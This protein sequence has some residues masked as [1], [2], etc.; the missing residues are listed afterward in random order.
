VDYY[1]KTSAVLAWQ[2]PADLS[3]DGAPPE[4]AAKV[5][6]NAAGAYVVTPTMPLH[7]EPFDWIV[8][9]R[10]PS[11]LI[12]SVMKGEAFSAAYAALG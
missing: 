2:L 3:L 5:R 11:G 8:G 1:L 6:V 10:L 4:L 7:A 12:V 9:H